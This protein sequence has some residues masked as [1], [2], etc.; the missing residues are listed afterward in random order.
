[1]KEPRAIKRQEKNALIEPIER[2]VDQLLR[3]NQVEDLSKIAAIWS[4]M[5]DLE[6]PM[7]PSL[8][9]AMTSVAD[10]IRATTLVDSKEHWQNAAVSAI[11]AIQ[12]D[13]AAF[14]RDDTPTH[15]Q[16]ETVDPAAKVVGFAASTGDTRSE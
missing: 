13:A 6:E 15:A 4:L 11:I 3:E 10:I 14:L 12:A 8:V 9:A 7:L 2:K 16:I 5:L 1:M